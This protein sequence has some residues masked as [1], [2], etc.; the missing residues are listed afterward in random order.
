MKD[1]LEKGFCT[2]SKCRTHIDPGHGMQ[3]V[4]DDG[5]LQRFCV[6]C[7]S[8]KLRREEEASEKRAAGRTVQG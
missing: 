5:Q 7:Y 1:A 4:D 8:D 3:W 2:R 6:P